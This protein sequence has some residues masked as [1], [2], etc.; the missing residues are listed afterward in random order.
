MIFRSVM[1]IPSTSL[2]AATKGNKFIFVFIGRQRI[3]NSSSA[4]QVLPL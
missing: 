1:I 2:I 3:N 4:Q